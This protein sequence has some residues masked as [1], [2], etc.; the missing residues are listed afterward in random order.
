M[1]DSFRGPQRGTAGDKIAELLCKAGQMEF[2]AVVESMSLRGMA[3]KTVKNTLRHMVEN[4]WLKSVDRMYVPVLKVLQQ[5]GAAPADPEV[6][7]IAAR[8][9]FKPLQTKNI[10]SL[11]PL[12]KDRFRTDVEFKNGSINFQVGYIPTSGVRVRS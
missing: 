6:I 8:Q 11:N 7:Q 9:T 3:Q 2:R 10:P 4:G 12:L 5:Y 1:K